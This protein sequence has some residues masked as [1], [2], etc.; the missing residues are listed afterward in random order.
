MNELSE[1]FGRLDALKRAA[2]RIADPADPLG[3]EAR[4]LLESSTGLSKAGVEY[5]L[6]ECLEHRAG[7]SVL[8]QLARRASPAQRA[9]VLLSANVFV[10]T[11][12]AIAVALAQSPRVFVRASRREPE[13]ARLLHQASGGAF[14]LVDALSPRPGDHL[15]AYAT[16]ETLKKLRDELPAG[17]CL[18]AH[19]AGLGI[20]VIGHDAPRRG[21]FVEA[22]A[23]ALARDVIAFDQRGCLSPRLTLVDGDQELA[24][25]FADALARSL[26]HYEQEVP[27]G[28]LS[29]EETADLLRYRDT[30]LYAARPL[31]A[32]K[33]LVVLDPMLD[34][35]HVP[36]VGRVVHVTRVSSVEP[37]VRALA[38]RITSVGMAGHDRLEG[39]LRTWLGDRRYVPLGKMQTPPLDGPVDLRA[40]WDAEV[41]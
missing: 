23:D 22:A 5:A 25:A 26:A 16:D 3:V 36:P 33:G 21:E 8:S 6:R 1:R 12:R 10:A 17:V 40:G 20:A 27:R 31:P 28:R 39:H 7:R 15:W 19:G 29:E 4:G 37:H 18:H 35:L 11:F 13:M 30:M 38:S 9:F 2:E 32:G 34:R 41:I 14:E 24:A